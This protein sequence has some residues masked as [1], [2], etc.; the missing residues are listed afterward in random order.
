MRKIFFIIFGVF[1]SFTFF[2]VSFAQAMYNFASIQPTEKLTV[3]SGKETTT[4]L[5]FYN[6]YGNNATKIKFS[7]HSDLMVEIKPENLTVE[8]TKPTKEKPLNVSDVEYLSIPGID[9]YVETKFVT[10]KVRAQGAAIGKHNLTITAVAEWFAAP[11]NIVQPRDFYYEIEVKEA[12]NGIS[13]NEIVS[14]IIIILFFLL[15]VVV[16]FW[17]NQRKKLRKK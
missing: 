3:E 7:A 15:L 10:I 6:V 5:Y 2:S 16:I 14:V 8:P 12:E 4:T 13:V 17:R 9:D 1:F 11:T